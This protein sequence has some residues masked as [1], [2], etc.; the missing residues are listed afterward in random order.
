MPRK[1]VAS[2]STSPESSAATG[3]EVKRTAR[4][5]NTRGLHARAAAKLARTAGQ[6]TSQVSVATGEAAVNAR[7]IM[8]LL[9]LGAPRGSELTLVA[10]GSDAKE[11]LEALVW[12]IEDGFGES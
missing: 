1:P 3:L 7:S 8:G 2:T 12:L 5:I 6:F 9:M 11:A 4:I 10:K